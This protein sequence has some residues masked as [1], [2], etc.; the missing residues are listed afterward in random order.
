MQVPDIEHVSAKSHPS[1]LAARVG[2]ASGQQSRQYFKIFLG[3]AGFF[4]IDLHIESQ[5][6]D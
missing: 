5:A 1:A 4:W 2:S 6:L 3:S